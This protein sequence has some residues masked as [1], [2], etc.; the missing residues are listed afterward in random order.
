M[1]VPNALTEVSSPSNLYHYA[2]LYYFAPA[3]LVQLAARAGFVPLLIDVLDALYDAEAPWA[4]G[5]DAGMTR[6]TGD[7]DSG[8]GP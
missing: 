2:H 5:A 7:A 3:P 1:E 8:S 6:T 4:G